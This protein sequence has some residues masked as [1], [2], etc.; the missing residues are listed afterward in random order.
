MRG[1]VK[2]AA[3][4]APEGAKRLYGERHCGSVNE[5]PV[6][7]QDRTSEYSMS[8]MPRANRM[9]KRRKNFGPIMAA[10]MSQN[11]IDCLLSW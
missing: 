6:P 8:A 9:T 5:N 1:P 4:A 11:L 7:F 3:S 10:K 2:A